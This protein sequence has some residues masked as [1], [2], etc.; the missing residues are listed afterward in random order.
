MRLS[1]LS[2]LLV[3]CGAMLL[4]VSWVARASERVHCAVDFARRASPIAYWRSRRFALVKR[5]VVN[6]L[7]GFPFFPDGSSSE[8]LLA[9]RT[10]QT[11]PY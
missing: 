5:F 2:A 10:Q 7:R 4:S 3:E 6:G 8:I 11:L 1:S 9:L